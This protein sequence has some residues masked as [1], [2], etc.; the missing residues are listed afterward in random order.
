VASLIGVLSKVVIQDMVVGQAKQLD[1]ARKAV[2]DKATK[3]KR[4]RY[5][6]ARIGDLSPKSLE[7]KRMKEER[8]AIRK[9]NRRARKREEERQKLPVLRGTLI[10]QD[11]TEH[12]AAC[13]LDFVVT[14]FV[15][16]IQNISF[17]TLSIQS[18]TKYKRLLS[19]HLHTIPLDKSKAMAIP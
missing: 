6:R 10:S 3:K 14:L 16:P 18:K 11:C 13:A 4:K 2:E 7:K 17:L 9:E 12:L 1:E 19:I 5:E 8:D 15:M